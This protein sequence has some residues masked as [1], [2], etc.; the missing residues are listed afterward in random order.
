MHTMQIVQ[1][2]LN[3]NNNI[4]TTATNNNSQLSSNTK[5]HSYFSQYFVSKKHTQKKIKK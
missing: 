5:A 2:L 1:F 4:K 3:A